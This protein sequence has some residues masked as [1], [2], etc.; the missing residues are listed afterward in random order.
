MGKPPLQKQKQNYYNSFDF[1]NHLFSIKADPYCIVNKTTSLLSKFSIPVYI[2]TNFIWEEKQK[3]TFF[4]EGRWV[5]LP[6]WVYSKRVTVE[7]INKL[8]LLWQIF[9]FGAKIRIG[10]K[11]KWDSI[12]LLRI[13]SYK[14]PSIKALETKGTPSGGHT[15]TTPSYIPNSV[16]KGE[17]DGR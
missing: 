10:I 4:R 16:E 14:R 5:W 3:L 2:N 12:L 11:S 9:F 1:G 8:F 7:T 13:V 17:F 15:T 6:N